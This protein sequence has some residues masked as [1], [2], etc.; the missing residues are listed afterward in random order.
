MPTKWSGSDKDLVYCLAHGIL[1]GLFIIISGIILVQASV[2]S[3]EVV[4]KAVVTFSDE[5]L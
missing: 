4:Q 1:L 3:S 5:L 2:Q